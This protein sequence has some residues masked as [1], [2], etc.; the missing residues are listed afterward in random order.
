MTACFSL[1]ASWIAPKR[2]WMKRCNSKPRAPMLF[3]LLPVPQRPHEDG[4]GRTSRL[5]RPRRSPESRLPE[6]SCDVGKPQAFGRPLQIFDVRRFVRSRC[7]DRQNRTL[8]EG[9][10]RRTISCAAG[11]CRASGRS[12]AALPWASATRSS[13][14]I[15][16]MSRTSIPPREMDGA[17]PSDAR[18]TR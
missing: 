8:L 10:A 11:I 5:F 4:R 9:A 18:R 7:R 14:A 1:S 6:R 16:R 2:W 17:G 13:P 12:R 15:S 3:K